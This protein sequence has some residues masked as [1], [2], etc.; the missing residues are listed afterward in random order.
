MNKIPFDETQRGL[1][2]YWLTVSHL[3]PIMQTLNLTEL[4]ALGSKVILARNTVTKKCCLICDSRMWKVT[5]EWST[6]LGSA[7]YIGLLHLESNADLREATMVAT[8]K[9][10]SL[11]H[12]PEAGLYEPR[13]DA[14][15]L[16]QILAV[17]Q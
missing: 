14:M 15:T 17:S 16:D 11:E 5:P 7:K 2:G 8:Q 4:C 13:P 10:E 12:K 6:T 3:A 9:I 1:L